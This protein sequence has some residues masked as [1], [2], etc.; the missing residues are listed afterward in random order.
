MCECGHAPDVADEMPGRHGFSGN[1]ISE[2]WPQLESDSFALQQFGEGAVA[3][4]KHD[5]W[6]EPPAIEL[7]YEAKGRYVISAD[8]VARERKAD[9][10]ALRGSGIS[11]A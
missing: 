5:E 11:A 10:R 7:L 6:L 3:V 4:A 9:D 8:D 1:E 2:G